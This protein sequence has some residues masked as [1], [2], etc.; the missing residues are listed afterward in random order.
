M[1]VSASEDS[2]EGDELDD[3]HAEIHRFMHK[4]AG[5]SCMTAG[6]L[7]ALAI[8]FMLCPSN[9]QVNNIYTSNV[10]AIAFATPI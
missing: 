2:A 8:L 6:W 7:G 1:D 4:G 9:W 5:L 10:Q 3:I